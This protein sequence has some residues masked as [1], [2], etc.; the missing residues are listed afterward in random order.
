MAE[1]EP[2][3]IKIKEKSGFVRQ[4][5]RSLVVGEKRPDKFRQWNHS[6]RLK[7]IRIP[8]IHKFFH[9]PVLG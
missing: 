8:P 4:Q 3:S 9:L 6:L 5:K 1:A 7:F 2:S